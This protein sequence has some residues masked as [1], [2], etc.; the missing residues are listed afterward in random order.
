MFTN[1]MTESLH[2]PA[3]HLLIPIQNETDRRCVGTDI[4]TEDSNLKCRILG[5]A[6]TT[7]WKIPYV[8]VC[9]C[10]DTCSVTLWGFLLP[11]TGSHDYVTMEAM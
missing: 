9:V 11:G 2:W 4:T 8:Y 10:M 1:E 6:W 7:K 3:V 5:D